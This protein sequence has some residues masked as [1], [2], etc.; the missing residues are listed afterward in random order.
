[1]EIICTRTGSGFSKILNKKFKK[2]RDG[3][4]KLL[5]E[6]EIHNRKQKETVIAEVEA[7]D[8]EDI[9][10][11]VA[12]IRELQDHWRTLGPAGKKLDPRDKS[13]V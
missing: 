11:S 9:D 8:K 4:N 1:M 2:A 10:A 3:V 5:E 6:V 12:R 7:L 13:T